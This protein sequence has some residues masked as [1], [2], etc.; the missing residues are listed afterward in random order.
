MIPAARIALVLALALGGCKKQEKAA[1]AENVPPMSTA[2]IQ[3]S[4]D[5]CKIYVDRACAC[6]APDAA[7]ACTMAKALPDAV[8]IG[9]EIAASPDSKPDIVRQSYASVRKTVKECI[10]LTAKLPALGCP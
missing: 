3:H 9:L 6:T 7:T 5:A 1:P 2:E 8:R 10:E 4:Q